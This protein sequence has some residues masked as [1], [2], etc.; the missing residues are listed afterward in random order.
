VNDRSAGDAA[1]RFGPYLVATVLLLADFLLV[2]R[3][4]GHVR[5]GTDYAA[6][7]L[8]HGSY[9]DVLKLSL[10]HYVRAGGVVHPLP[11]VHDRIEYPV[12][13]GFLLWLPAWLPG[14]PASW[15]AAAGV[16]TAAATFASIALLRRMNPRSAW[17]IA[18]SPALLLD[19]AINWDLVGIAFLIA[20]VVFFAERRHRLSGAAAAVGTWVKLFPVIVA[21]MA[22]A[23]LGSRWWRAGRE[24]RDAARAWWRWLVPFAVVS[25][26]IAVPFLVVARSNTLWFVRYNSTRPEKDSLWGLLARVIGHWAAGSHFADTASLLVVLAA[27]GFGAWGVWRAALANPARAVALASAI[28][29]VAWMAVNKVWNPQYLLWVFAAG[30]IAAAPAPLFVALGAVTLW[31]NWF[32]FVLRVPDHANPY[33]WIGYTSVVARTAVFACL[34]GWCALELHRLAGAR[35]PVP[36]APVPAPTPA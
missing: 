26:V 10:D 15:L 23:A 35:S 34:A 31:D 9:S 20:S 19:A 17:W 13:L 27:V 8:D 5:A 6:W 33:S 16:M 11:Y 4:L 21:P 3:S 28:A 18:A 7:A 1:R 25:L 29:L 32:E 30:A 24:P 2:A 12:L 36:D 14:G 22:L